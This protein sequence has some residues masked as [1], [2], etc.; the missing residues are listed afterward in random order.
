MS[1]MRLA[2]ATAWLKL[3]H[4]QCYAENIEVDWYQ[5]MTY[6]ICDPCPHV[7]S[8]FLTKL[9]QGLLCLKLPLEYMAMF[10]H[11]ADV[12]DP[13]FKQRAKQLLISNVQ[14]RRDFLARHP[15]YMNDTKFLYGLLPDFILPYLIYLLAH[16]PEWTDPDDIN[17][18]TRIKRY[19]EL[20]NNNF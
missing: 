8:R 12:A 1:R 9:S 14:R 13:A 19:V 17:R 20:F 3:A 2:A 16:D 5:S 6:I 7:R 4:S 15:T 10:A 11:A 18:L